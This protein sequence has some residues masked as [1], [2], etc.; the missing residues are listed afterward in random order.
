VT[1]SRHA[2][3]ALVEIVA[4][5]AILL[6]LTGAIF[7][8]VA[9]TDA[10]WAREPA[11][12]DVHDRLRAA[13]EALRQPL[14]EAGGSPRTPLGGLPLGLIVPGVLPYRIG[15]RQADPPG[16]FHPD[17]VTMVS[18]LPGAAAP[19]I[20]G[21][22]DGTAALLA[23]DAVPGCP[24]GDPA[25]GLE[26][27]MTVL[28]LD[29]SGQAD[30]YGVVTVSA[31]LV[32]LVARG[33]ATRR[34]YLSG[35]RL[36]PLDVSTYYVRPPAG[37]DGPQLAKYD[38]N[39]SDLPVVD[40]VVALSV[41][42]FA[43]P[44]PPRLRAQAGPGGETMTYGPAPPPRGEDDERDSWGAGENC[45]I[46]DT[47][48]GRVARLP[49]LGDARSHLWPLS[50]QSL[51]D[52]PW[53]P[54]SAAAF[55]FDADLLRIRKV[56]VT[57]RVEAWSSTMRGRDARLFARPGTSSAPGRWV[58]DE[59]VTFDVVPRAPGGSR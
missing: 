49:E 15:L 24:V 2:G 20:R 52:G 45:V 3:F 10:G 40:H 42:Y 16:T 4:A 27:G 43:D 18:S 35:A 26:P 30:L 25:C 11:V 57:V 37:A 44:Q 8:V 55:R 29:T 23:V 48:S 17:V 56:R 39:E 58:P 14:L 36:V 28:L 41:E 47:G 33:A 19:T 9:P 46:Q 31:D 32:G 1:C 13:I 12:T 22:F 6:T 34:R 50:A 5:T 53:C 7:L 54:D 38:G 59:R 51:A 21:D